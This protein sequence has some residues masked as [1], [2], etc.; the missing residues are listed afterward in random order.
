MQ[1][2]GTARIGFNRCMMCTLS[3]VKMGEAGR[4]RGAFS[5]PAGVVRIFPGPC[6]YS[7]FLEDRGAAPCPCIYGGAGRACQNTSPPSHSFRD[8]LEGDKAAGHPIPKLHPPYRNRFAVLYRSRP[9]LRGNSDSSAWLYSHGRGHEVVDRA[10]GLV[11][12]LDDSQVRPTQP[13]QHLWSR[14]SRKQKIAPSLL[15]TTGCR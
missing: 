13:R 15:Q 2:L 1:V 10:H 3:G 9:H 4:G 8:S 11:W 7:H 6:L 12:L 5:P 14:R